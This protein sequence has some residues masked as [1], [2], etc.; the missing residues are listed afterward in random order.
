MQDALLALAAAPHVK[1]FSA[2]FVGQGNA[3]HASQNQ[4]TRRTIVSVPSSLGRVMQVIRN[5]HR[6]QGVAQR[7]RREKSKL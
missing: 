1:R 7:I 6:Q 5:S 4:A 2:L 3:G